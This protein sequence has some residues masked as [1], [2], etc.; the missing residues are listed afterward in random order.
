MNPH[1]SSH[2]AAQNLYRSNSTAAHFGAVP[3]RAWMQNGAIPH[4]VIP[5]TTTRPPPPRRNLN[6]STPNL[7]PRHTQSIQPSIPVSE[8]ETPLRAPANSAPSIANTIWAS[9]RLEAG[10]AH[11]PL[12]PSPA[13]SDDQN[14]YT[15]SVAE[16]GNQ[17]SAPAATSSILVAPHTF[18]SPSNLN[19]PTVSRPAAP[20]PPGN[21][22]SVSSS[23]HADAAAKRN[24]D[25]HTSEQQKRQRVEQNLE[26]LPGQVNDLRR[27]A[28]PVAT[29]SHNQNSPLQPQMFQASSALQTPQEQFLFQIDWFITQRTVRLTGLERQRCE[30]LKTACKQGDHFYLCLH[31]LFCYAHMD[32]S[33]RDG[34]FQL[35]KDA[36]D[37]LKHLSTFI[38]SNSEISSDA[39]S[40][41]GSHLTP[42]QADIMGSRTHHDYCQLAARFLQKLGQQWKQLTRLCSTR[43]YPLFVEEMEDLLLLSSPLLQSIIFRSLHRVISRSE[44]PFLGEHT[45]K[46]FASNREEFIKRS[47]SGCLLSR[48]QKHALIA[49]LGWRYT[50]ALNHWN[51]SLQASYVQPA[52]QQTNLQA[53]SNQF[54]ILPSNTTWVSHSSRS[55]GAYIPN[56]HHVQ[57]PQVPASE[58][59]SSANLPVSNFNGFSAA[60]ETGNL[61]PHQAQASGSHSGSIVNPLAFSASLNQATLPTAG[62]SLVSASNNDLPGTT[63]NFSHH[64]ST[65]QAPTSMQYESAESLAHFLAYNSMP[66]QKRSKDGIADPDLRLYRFVKGFKL[67]PGAL[68]PKMP[69]LQWPIEISEDEESLKV[70]QIFVSPKDSVPSRMY[71][72]GSLLFQLRC[73]RVANIHLDL[74]E[75]RWTILDHVWPKSIFVEINKAHPSL[76]KKDMFGKDYPFDLTPFLRRGRNLLEITCLLDEDEIKNSVYAFAVEIIEVA[77]EIYVKDQPKLL[78]SDA[79]LSAITQGLSSTTDDDDLAIVDPYLSIDLVDPFM[80][81]IFNVPVRGRGCMHRECFD[82]DTFLQTRKSQHKGMPTTPDDWKCPICHRDARPSNLVIDG[83]LVDVRRKLQEEKRTDA[84]ALQVHPDGSW[85]VKF[86]S[87]DGNKRQRS[88][89]PGHNTISGDAVHDG[90]N[91]GVIDLDDE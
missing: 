52:I 82:L 78:S 48:Q 81:T 32:P 12:L 67:G 20:L 29:S 41:F 64:S 55:V 36:E 90:A 43:K 85:D 10:N 63:S 50:Q 57:V 80:A 28:Q 2:T 9:S 33:T 76:R 25:Q 8:V 53:V 68:N 83:F 24:S 59:P 49:G 42:F 69:N 37:G 39:L 88:I 23:C 40:F 14:D 27:A 38:K 60:T 45:D 79:C 6:I 7:S 65:A 3:Q 74:A 77:D 75:D 84:K 58:T 18:P 30:L 17:Y 1:Q 34:H 4:L 70:K 89:T 46:I 86:E 62:T 66:Y 5:A 35:H 26:S 91:A 61:L 13:P 87:S 19:S 73:A 71:C 56:S 15:A 47:R 21:V 22:V 51:Q 31:R 72:P 54:Q 44:N 11:S 16:R